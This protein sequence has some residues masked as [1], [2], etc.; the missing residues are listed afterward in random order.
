M[1]ENQIRISVRVIPNAPRNQVASQ[2]D[3]VWK[4]KV[5]APPQK[6]KANQELLEFLA[7]KLALKRSCVLLEKGQ[8]ARHKIVALTGI[9][10]REVERLLIPD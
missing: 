5:A 9:S 4:I 8:T 7:R 3:G 10:Q 2:S 6:G 1:P